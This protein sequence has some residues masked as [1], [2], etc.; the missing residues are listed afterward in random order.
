MSKNKN[1]KV[2]EIDQ[3]WRLENTNKATAIGFSNGKSGSILIPSKVKKAVYQILNEKYGRTNSNNLRLF[4]CGILL[5]IK[6]HEL[7]NYTFLIDEEYPSH[8]ITLVDMIIKRGTKIGLKLS[9]N[10]FNIVNIGKSEA[11]WVSIKTFKNKKFATKIIK[12]NDI[13]GIIK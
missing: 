2:V 13:L 11:H 12:L 1:S 3:S 4:S 10:Q 6:I 9:K 7:T 8:D 5:L